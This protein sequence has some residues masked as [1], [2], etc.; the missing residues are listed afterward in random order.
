MVERAL[1]CRGHSVCDA[2]HR[3]GRR[4]RGI[5]GEADDCSL[6]MAWGDILSAVYYPLSVG[7][8]ADELGSQESGDASGGTCDSLYRELHDEFA[9]CVFAVEAL[10]LAGEGMAD[11]E[12]SHT[13][14]GC[15]GE[16]MI[17]G[18]KQI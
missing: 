5:E 15:F 16:V 17:P 3:C 12:A 11:G 9:D 7:L 1:L 14:S 8:H 10:R 2:L 6:Q 4:W 18:K 13:E